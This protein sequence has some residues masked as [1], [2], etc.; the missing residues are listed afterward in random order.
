MADLPSK[1][2]IYNKPNKNQNNNISIPQNINKENNKINN[3]DSK[4]NIINNQNSL[5]RSVHNRPPPPIANIYNN[6]NMNNINPN[7]RNPQMNLNQNHH[8]NINNNP[9]NSYNNNQININSNQLNANINNV[10]NNGFNQN[11][12]RGQPNPAYIPPTNQIPP[13][14]PVYIKSSNYNYNVDR[15]KVEQE[16]RRSEFCALLFFYCS[17]CATHILF[18]FCCLILRMFRRGP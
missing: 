7:E 4:I 3:D 1:E 13:I 18:Y 16:Y 15:I 8:F 14:Q 6:S 5:L 17:W 2:E 11:N 10:Y 12:N 9:Y